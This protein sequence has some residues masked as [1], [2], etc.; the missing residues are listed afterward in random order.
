LAEGLV[1]RSFRGRKR[2][3]FPGGSEVVGGTGSQK[4]FL[5]RKRDRFSGGSEVVGGTG[6][7]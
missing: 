1:L 2:D 4:N 5:G 7:H 3:R 6:S